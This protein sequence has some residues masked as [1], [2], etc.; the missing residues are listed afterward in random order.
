ME[1]EF[2][3]LG[4]ALKPYHGSTCWHLFEW[5]EGR[6]KK[7][8]T[9]IE[10]GWKSAEFFPSTLEYGLK[11][12]VERSYRRSAAVG[13]TQA[14]LDEVRRINAVMEAYCAPDANG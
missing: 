9:P 3:E 2:R 5:A 6:K 10:D 12:I 11:T 4:Y 13:D 1:I 8:G 14:I 7:D